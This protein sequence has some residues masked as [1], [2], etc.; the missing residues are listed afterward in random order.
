MTNLIKFIHST[1]RRP[2]ASPACGEPGVRGGAD[3]RRAAA[4]PVIL[5][6]IR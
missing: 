6:A 1:G 2:L 5:R 4:R 3:G